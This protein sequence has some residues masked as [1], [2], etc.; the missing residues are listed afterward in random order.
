MEDNID[1]LDMSGFVYETEENHAK[2]D[3]Y[4]HGS[5]A[6]PV[7]RAAWD[8]YYALCLICDSIEPH[9]VYGIEKVN[10]A[11]RKARGGHEFMKI[12]QKCNAVICYDEVSK[13]YVNHNTSPFLCTSCTN[14]QRNDQ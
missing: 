14:K 1:T 9:H 7:E 3:V 11:I 2:I 6:V 12:C 10:E 4:P 13:D 8:M 5:L